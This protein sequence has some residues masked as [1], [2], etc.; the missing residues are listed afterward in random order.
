MRAEKLAIIAYSLDHREN[1][2]SLSFFLSLL[3]LLQ[4]PWLPSRIS[5]S[6][7]LS[8]SFLFK[9]I[10][11]LLGASTPSP[12]VLPALPF[13]LSA[14]SFPFSPLF[15]INSEFYLIRSPPVCIFIPTH[16]VA[17]PKL[18]YERPRPLYLLKISYVQSV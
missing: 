8:I 5:L 1:T 4:L 12:P 10:G 6:T 11:K 17:K 3:F 15:S 2:T 18:E 14:R 7:F 16:T 9:F 13:S